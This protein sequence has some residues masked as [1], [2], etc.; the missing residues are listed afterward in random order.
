MKRTVRI[1]TAVAIVALFAVTLSAT[2][3]RQQYD[4]TFDVSEG[5]RLVL[6]NVNG[7]VT[8]E[9][10]DQSKV[11]VEAELKVKASG[12][13]RAEEAM[14]KLKIEVNR[15]GDTL[16]VRTRSPR[17]ENGGF[18]SWIFGSNADYEVRYKVTMP[19][20]FDADIETVNG[21]IEANELAGKLR[22]ETTNG[23]I[24][25]LRAA[26]SVDASTTNG[27]IR[28]ELTEVNRVP[29]RLDTTNGRI[30]ISLPHGAGVNV[31]AATTNGSIDT[32]FAISTTSFR[33]NRIAGEINGGG[34]E[35]R[36]RTTNGSIRIN[37]S[38]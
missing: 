8:V 3:L 38:R 14:S 26:G 10:W 2:T 16:E 18:L 32:D 15:E 17:D 5:G 28:A 19:K 24:E 9:S 31:D 13:D 21:H 25:V 33:R 34:P 36:L 11:R 1:L 6:S 27:S 7:S 30:E 23:G 37:E 4:K 29:M 12:R 20:K 35:L 22:F